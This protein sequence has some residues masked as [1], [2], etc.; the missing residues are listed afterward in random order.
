MCALLVAFSS[1]AS[2]VVFVGASLGA[3]WINNNWN[4]IKGVLFL[5]CALGRAIALLNGKPLAVIIGARPC[6]SLVGVVSL[7]AA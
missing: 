5:C 6:S 4:R 2:W 1:D 3:V 7:S